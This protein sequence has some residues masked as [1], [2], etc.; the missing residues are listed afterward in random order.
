MW[1]TSMAEGTYIVI[2]GVIGVGKTTL[3]QPL[4]EAFGAA[5]LLEAVEENPFLGDF[6]SD[7]ARY[8]FQTQVFFTLNRYR[9]QS[10]I[11]KGRQAIVSDYLFAKNIIFAELN[12]QGDELALYRTFYNVLVERIRRPDLVIFLQASLPTLQARIIQRERPFERQMDW[13]Y[14]TA[15]REA[16]DSFFASYDQAPLLPIETDA[17]DLV[18]DPAALSYVLGLVRAS[19]AG[20]RQQGLAFD[21]S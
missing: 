11:V 8:A 6:Y 1:S 16:Y 4:G 7:R 14:I 20:Y 13:G 18:R 3:A 10:E 17:L 9:Q 2:E 12:L 15:V 21:G 19:L 5:I